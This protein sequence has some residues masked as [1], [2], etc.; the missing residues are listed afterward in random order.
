MLRQKWRRCIAFLTVWVMLAGT[1]LTNV[2]T[3]AVPTAGG[4]VVLFEDTFDEPVETLK[5]WKAVPDQWEV[6]NQENISYLH[7]FH[8]NTRT[9]LQNVDSSGW[10]DYRVEFRAKFSSK[11]A[12]RAEFFV[13]ADQSGNYYSLEAQLEQANAGTVTF[14]AHR[15]ANTVYQGNLTAN[16]KHA[17]DPS[18][19]H[20]YTVIVT[21]NTF[22]LHLD[23]QEIIAAT[24]PNGHYAAGHI[25]FRSNNIGLQV[26]R[27]KV[28]GAG[29]QQ[30]PVKELTLTHT[31]LAQVN[32]A[33]G[34]EITATITAPTPVT[35]AVYYR[36]GYAENGGPWN[37]TPMIKGADDRYQAQIPPPSSSEI[38]TLNYYIEASDQ[39]GHYKS[40][41]FRDDFS[42]V[43][44]S[45]DRWSQLPEQWDIVQDGGRQT[46]KAK[47]SNTRNYLT[48][49]DTSNW[50]DYDVE[51]QAKL[52]KKA[53]NTRAEFFIRASETGNYYAIETQVA[54]GSDTVI[55][56]VHYWENGVYKQNLAPNVTTQLNML[57]WNHYRIQVRDNKLTLFANGDELISA[58]DTANRF[59]TG[60][61]GFRSNNVDLQVADVSL[62]GPVKVTGGSQLTIAHTPKSS[63][64]YNTDVPVVFETTDTGSPQTATLH[65]HYGDT[66]V[67][68]IEQRKETG[69]TYT[70]T[71]PGLNRGGVIHY[72]LEIKDGTGRSARYPQTGELTVSSGSFV[73]YTAGF[74]DVP[75]GKA[76]AGW[77]VRGDV[78]VAELPEGGKALRLNGQV[79]QANTS[80]ILSD[81]NYANMDN[82]S[83]K[84]RAKYVRTSDQY[85]NVWRLRYRT[86]NDNNNYSM[87]W[88][89]HNWRYFIM[90]KTDLGGNY[91]LGTHNEAL[92]NQWVD[93]EVRVSGI[94][95]ELYINGKRVI[96]TD[97]FDM[98]RMEKG[99]IQFG[100]VSG[101]NLLI[102]SLEITPLEASHIYHVE[103]ADNYTGIYGPGQQPGLKIHLAGGSLPHTYRVQYTVRRADGNRET[104]ATGAKDYTVAA[105]SELNEKLH[106]EPAVTGI[107]TYDV[108]VD[109]SI[110]GVRQEGAAKK[111]R[112]AV[113]RELSVNTEQD[114]LLESKF[115]VNT[116]Y[117]TNW[118]DD[119]ME[120]VR[121]L[122][123]RHH[124]SHMNLADVFT[125]E[126]DSQGRPVF[127]FEKEDDYLEKVASFGLNQ[128][129]V[130][131]FLEDTKKAASYDGL[132]LIEDFTRESASRYKD[133]I[134]QFE[135]PNE[136]ENYVKPYIPYEIVQQW[137]RSYIGAKDGN[138]D[139]TFIAGDHTSS[140]GSVLPPELALGAYHYADAFSWHPY[141][142]NAMP[143]GAIEKYIDNVSSMLDA[144]GGWK[145]FYLTE[146]GWPT[147]KGGHPSVS[148]E[149]QRDYIVRAFLIYMTQ[150]QVRAWEYYNF[151]N[152]GTDENY[153]EIFWG[154]TDVDGRPKLSYTAANNL[155][156]T[157]DRAEYAGRL[158]TQDSKVRAYVFLKES[159]PIIAAWRS[160]DHNDK[161]EQNS[162]TSLLTVPVGTQEV[163]VRDINGNDQRIASA[164]GTVQ[165]TVSGSP[166]YILG[167]SAEL[168]YSAN[169]E[170][171]R[172]Y[173]Q[174]AAQRIGST[175]TG[176]TPAPGGALQTLESIQ[177]GFETALQAASPAAKSAGL[178]QEIVQVYALM[179]TLAS[180]IQSG[181][182]DRVKTFAALET[183][184]NYAE[185]ASKALIQAKAAEG[186]PPSIPEYTQGL[187]KTEAAY[188]A[189]LGEDQL[190]PVSTSALLRAKRYADLAAKGNRQ[191]RY[192]ES[193]AYGLLAK[194]FAKTLEQIVAA[195]EPIFVGLWLNVTPIRLNGEPGYAST[196]TGTV[197]NDTAEPRAVTVRLERPDGW[198]EP[199][200]VTVT[201]G[202]NE[203]YPF[204]FPLHVPLT[205][206]KGLY[207]PK[208]IIESGGK[209]IDEAR[210]DMRVNDSIE[211]RILP[212]TS[213]VE[214]LEQVE[215]ELKG[216]S[217]H[218]KTGKVVLRGPDGQ[219]LS[220]MGGT[221]F[222][223]LTK[224]Q[225]MTMTFAW[226]YRT[227]HDYNEYVNELTVTD[228]V[229]NV[230]IFRDEA[231]LDFLLVRKRTGSLVVDGKL[232]E[233]KRAFPFHLRGG[234]RT[235]TGI[236]DPENVSAT[237]YLLWDQEQLYLGVE[238]TDNIHKN[239]ENPPNLW[240]ND[241]VQTAIDP[242]HDSSASYNQDDME[243][244]FAVHND[245]A[246]VSNIFFSR[247][248]NQNGNV[249]DLIPYRIVRDEQNRK[250]YY[251]IQ[252]PKSMIH[253]LHLAEGSAF[254][255]N[256]AVNDADMQAGRDNFIQWTTGL[257]DAKNPGNFDLFTL[258]DG[259][260]Q[261]EP[262]NDASV[263]LKVNREMTELGEETIVTVAVDHAKDLY[264]ID[265]S[266]QYDRTR[267]ALQSVELAEPFKP[268]GGGERAYVLHTETDGR[269]RAVASRVA[270]EHGVSGEADVLRFRFRA[271]G[272]PG[273]TRWQLNPHTAIS[274]SDGGVATIVLG[275]DQPAVVVDSK[276]ITG[277][278][279]TAEALRLL[280]GALGK[281]SGEDGFQVQYDLN[282]DGRIGIVDL[283]YV[284]LRLLS[285]EGTNP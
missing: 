131:G 270:E 222:A 104:V 89:T 183:L 134:R 254:R 248:P 63:V 88:G 202:P 279:P 120:A 168:L 18:E 46:M 203:A 102:D 255:Y 121:K 262:D 216:V 122:G 75:T 150:P 162:P 205:A 274:D 13:R 37:N 70:M 42:N 266:L 219:E 95:H 114:M 58:T 93:Y 133:R 3:A 249:S 242:L 258:T 84:F 191:G 98:L 47:N 186:T 57:Q 52:N 142:Y 72:Y 99:Y 226:N 278:E 199:D 246:H 229:N 156:T 12:G 271:A 100:T 50:S 34:A 41:G 32:V 149:V 87:E 22:K 15:W 130:L 73:P 167:A 68:S 237:A 225:T 25:G 275:D 33:T 90:R 11:A 190:L 7:G 215:V 210:I 164:N 251:E 233:W 65:Y 55:L 123:A 159:K 26:D 105:Y 141:V 178:E 110:D 85:Y 35:A 97:D 194:E 77:T 67:K 19:W 137:K 245:G 82:F 220:P 128:I 172:D 277:S 160:V 145:D 184:Y 118:R 40:T 24:D 280:G 239:S 115:G 28:L 244:G 189:K 217:D 193:Y 181:K 60:G 151:K 228:T 211:A 6:K 268:V 43:Q 170:L 227:P 64:A 92:E 236:Y 101:I 76:P 240:K 17:Y 117:S 56:K 96:A 86:Q 241:S 257:A 80:A 36:Y 112:M 208:V 148:E 138:P 119:L 179:K 232:D 111:M 192:A 94:T 285:R 44:R 71:I 78:K 259:I 281:R 27:V 66:A 276:L 8:T 250:T 253:D 238:V 283:A 180:E 107:G 116:H 135:T 59:P 125:G 198:G 171:L 204:S 1:V 113:V 252:M 243:W 166:I 209:L 16:V 265:L 264:A 161:P 230:T 207:T 155:M 21:G 31:P 213:S 158:S 174:E 169:A 29:T 201:L 20:D 39:S 69:G 173:K 188:K 187:L 195:D 10:N 53:D 182:L 139:V 231:P 206:G 144:Y 91:Y 45:A 5:H 83:L 269:V 153:Y 79:G 212:V 38:T 284:A 81:P 61:I 74:D 267:Y 30:E 9:F 23:G 140:V 143:D 282:A 103:P 260:T 147:A 51:F 48:G 247:P 218:P 4:E 224:G 256:V 214:K 200:S 263:K 2:A 54:S 124:R 62:T 197:A 176:G 146:G 109:L 127:H 129:P 136:P 185:I 235:Q 272:T 49:L 196:V 221:T 106:F 234:K 108:T 175:P 165:V 126:Y 261:Q 177:R 223:N 152:D 132:K 14:K 157:L 273:A 163:T 154:M